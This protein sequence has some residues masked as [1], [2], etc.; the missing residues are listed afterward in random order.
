MLLLPVW[1][2][3]QTPSIMP[4]VTYTNP[5]GMTLYGRYPDDMNLQEVQNAPLQAFFRSNP[6]TCKGLSDTGIFEAEIGACFRFR[7][8][9]KPCLT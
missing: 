5:E 7:P 1:V 8:V 3:A 9:V 2:T 4:E 6:R